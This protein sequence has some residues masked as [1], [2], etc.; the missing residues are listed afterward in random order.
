MTDLHLVLIGRPVIHRFGTSPSPVP[1]SLQPFL[2]FLSLERDTGCH[3]DRVIE[4]LW[5]DIPSEQGRRRL[6]TTV[7]RARRLLGEGRNGVLVAS[8]AGHLSLDSAALAIDVAPAVRALSDKRRA[9]AASGDPQA[10]EELRR[11]VLVEASAFMAGNYHE[12]VVRA[13]DR[14]ELAVV[15]GVATLLELA[16]TP[17]DAIGWAELLVRLDPLREDA[18]RRLM[19]LYAETGR[20]ADALRQYDLCAGRLR[21]EIGVEPLI[22]TTLVATA[23]R[24][25]ITPVPTDLSDARSVRCALREALQSCR[26]V[27]RN[28]E[29]AIATL[30]PD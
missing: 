18:H 1:N 3:R 12:W 20:R 21:D 28:I 10:L 25:G 26:D 15:N 13:R 22:E 8:R 6:N 17:S 23:I 30:P 9:A 19:R 4:S 2:G 24:E 14:L 11:A 16:S 27:V 29:S 7:W 5:P